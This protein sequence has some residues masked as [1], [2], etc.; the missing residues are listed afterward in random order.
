MRITPQTTQRACQLLALLALVGLFAIYVSPSFVALCVPYAPAVDVCF[1]DA[2]CLTVLVYVSF[3]RSRRSDLTLVV[4]V[5]S[6]L[7]AITAAGIRLTTGHVALPHGLEMLGVGAA[8]TMAGFLPCQ[9]ERLRYLRRTQPY[10]T[11][12]EI[13]A[14]DRRRQSRAANVPLLTND[15]DPASQRFG[16]RATL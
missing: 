4:N 2:F 10:R 8:G 5:A 16:R 9:V 15:P 6:V 11:F 1:I 14:S 13:A 7:L 3:P 12:S